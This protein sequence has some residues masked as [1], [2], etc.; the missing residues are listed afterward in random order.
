MIHAYVL[1]PNH[2]HLICSH[3]EGR[4]SDV[5]RDMKKHTS[6]ELAAKLE[7]DGRQV[8]LNAMRKAARPSGGVRVWDEAFHPEQIHSRPFFDQKLDYIHNNPVRAGFVDEPSHWRYSSAGLYYH[9]AESP[10][11]VVPVEW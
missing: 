5:M 3:T 10:V 2:F 6:K 4:F 7:E 11:P 8:W 9:E 1:M